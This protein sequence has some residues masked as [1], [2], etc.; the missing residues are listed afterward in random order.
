MSRGALNP[1]LESSHH[2]KFGI[3]C[4]TKQAPL[5]LE[6]PARLTL[7]PFGLLFVDRNVLL[8]E[9]QRLVVWWAKG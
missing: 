7:G 8:G 3:L 2:G 5:P 6:A 4:D 1:A 9:A